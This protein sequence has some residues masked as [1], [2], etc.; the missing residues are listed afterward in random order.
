[1]GG[2]GQVIGVARGR[3]GGRGRQEANPENGI[4]RRK[5]TKGEARKGKE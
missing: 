5:I 3:G 1:M 2:R 4:P